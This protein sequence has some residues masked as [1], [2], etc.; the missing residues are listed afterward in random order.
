MQVMI[1][2][3]PRIFDAQIMS[4]LRQGTS[5]RVDPSVGCRWCSGVDRQCGPQKLRGMVDSID[6]AQSST[7]IWQIKLGYFGTACKCIEICLGKP[8]VWLL[9]SDDG[10]AQ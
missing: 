2:R 9:Q 10:G 5:F 7:V 8:R 4:S 6:V 3:E 1:R